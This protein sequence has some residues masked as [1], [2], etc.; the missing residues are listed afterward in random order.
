MK[1]DPPELSETNRNISPAL[2]RVVRQCLEK[3]PEERFHSAHD[4]ALALEALAATSGQSAVSPTLAPTRRRRRLLPA[5][6]TFAVLAGAALGF[7]AGKRTG[8]P[9]PPSFHQLTF[10]RGT[11]LSARF[12]PDGQTII[13]GA[14]WEGN[15]VE[16]FSTRPESSAWRSLGLS[17][18]DILAISSSGEMAIS[19]GRRS[20]GGVLSQGTLARTPLA[21]GAPREILEDVQA[22]DWAPDGATLAVVRE[23]AGRS[24]LEFPIGK[25][26]YETSGWI[27]DPRISPKGDLVAFLD[28]PLQGDDG[29]AVAAVD[30][31]GKKK[32]LSPEWYSERGLAWS[33]KG[34]EVWFTATKVGENRALY[35]VTL[36]G[37]ERLVM[38]VAGALTLHDISRD[39][40][41][42]LTRDNRRNGV[43][44]LP[45]GAAK[46]RDL[47][48]LD[49][50]NAKAISADGKAFLFDE[51][52]EG[53]GATYGVYLRKTDGGPAVRLGEGGALALSPDGKWA[54]SLQFVPSQQLVLL[55]TGPGQPKPLRGD[56]IKYQDWGAWLPD[57]KHILFSGNEPGRGTRC[58]VQDLEGGKP[59]P[60]TPEGIGTSSSDTVSPDGRVVAL[61]GPNQN[62]SL[63]S[64]E[65]GESYRVP[66]VTAGD[67]PMRWSANGRSLYVF[68]GEL[69]AKV[70]RLD[71]WTGHR[72]LWK[73]I[74]PSDP[75]GS[76]AI[77]GIL[78]TPD[79][80]S[81]VYSYFRNLSDLYLVEGLK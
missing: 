35:A 77:L 36:S 30:P 75:A 6:V 54:L 56:G 17:D 31:A 12:G 64:V 39:R 53:G 78:A 81:Y 70:Y 34:D 18:T 41:V 5:L 43:I 58:Y 73:E 25:V 59:R 72:E 8:Y 32:I 57:G 16:I 46:E 67:L 52:G 2:E 38:R 68:Q 15:P 79:W 80:K 23:A 50:S 10:R 27:S 62:I 71:L 26:L 66:G 33:P 63:Y 1:E 20:L 21:G 74:M 48:W 47:S 22:A 42:L 28:H 7:F 65:G 51:T 40:R 49:W 61:I 76:L 45:P 44:G 3:N 29:G 9:P 4:L 24:R 60:I 13:Y 11:I 55:P 19:L 69:P 14:A 37:R